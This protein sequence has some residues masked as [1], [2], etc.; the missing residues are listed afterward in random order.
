MRVTPYDR[1]SSFLLAAVLASIVTV[2]AILCWWQAFRPAPITHDPKPDY[3]NAGFEDG[4]PNETLQI[5]SPEAPNPHATSAVDQADEPRT[6]E[7]LAAVVELSDRASE[8]A[9]QLLAQEVAGGAAPGTIHGTSRPLGQRPGLGVGIAREDRWFVKF[10]DDESQEEYAR[11]LDWF[12]IELGVVYPERGEIVYVSQLSQAIPSRRVAKTDQDETRLYMTWVAG[13]RKAADIALLQKAGIDPT[14]GIV[15]QFYPPE[16]EVLLA[17]T[18]R[19]FAH[20][21]ERDIRR[22]YFVIVP[23][24]NTYVFAVTRQTYWR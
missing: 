13:Q 7:A 23:R 9:Q 1:V 15:L 24:G 22:T 10:A 19:S 12:G 8:Q 5:E 17:E 21:A 18:E 14:G 16:T 11:Q 6:G 3:I 20:R 2:I 4:A